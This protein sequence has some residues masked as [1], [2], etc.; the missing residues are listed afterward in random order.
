MNTQVNVLLLVSYVATR[1]NLDESV[2]LKDKTSPRAVTDTSDAFS[3][4]LRLNPDSGEDAKCVQE[5][6]V[7]NWAIRI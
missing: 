1:I 7:S 6:G 2:Q 5:L 3:A 4:E